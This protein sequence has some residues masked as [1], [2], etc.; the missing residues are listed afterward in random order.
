MSES[1]TPRLLLGLAVTLIAVVVFAWFSLRQI[2][3]MRQMQTNTIERKRRDSLQLLRIQDNLNSLALAMRDMVQG[4]EPY[5]PEAWRG[6]FQRIRED[7]RDALD[8]EDRLSSRP[9]EQT[10]YLSDSIAQ[11]WRSADEMFA[12]A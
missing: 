6:E 12:V 8:I 10:K 1:P 3:G 5:G 7:L 9:S 11:F 4:E 2:S